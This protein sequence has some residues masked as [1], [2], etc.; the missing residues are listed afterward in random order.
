VEGPFSF[1]LAPLQQVFSGLGRAFNDLFRSAGEL[2][3][4][5]QR[6]QVLQGQVDNLT[7]ENV[8]LR[9]FQAEVKQYREL[10]KFANDN[11]AFTV[12]GADVIGVGNPNCRP[13][14]V[15]QSAAGV[16][17][18]VISGDPSPYARYIT[19]NVGR[20]NGISKGMPVVG[21]GFALV[22]R[23]GQV[24]ET[25][26]EVELLVDSNSY[27]N[28]LLVGSRATGVVAGQSDGSLHLINVAQTEEVKPGDLI[29]TSGLGGK[30]PR[31]L[32]IGQV[33]RVIS[34]DAQLFKEALVRPAI[35]FNR[36]EVVLVITAAQPQN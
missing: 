6:V 36:I 32:T 25:S 7:T 28:A 4:L 24:N 31:L 14:V 12:V 30:L 11:P 9:E 29:V 23:I 2:Q 26:S 16:C 5:R 33:D 20:V 19:I 21:G 18:N 17:A 15:D 3:D 34:T 1:V 8:R 22:G 13:G 10:L 27:V 35:D